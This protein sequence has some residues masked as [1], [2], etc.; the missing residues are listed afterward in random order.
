M[1]I[2]QAIAQRRSTYLSDPDWMEVPWSNVPKT[3]F[4]QL[5]DIMVALPSI[6]EQGHH[7]RGLTSTS[8]LLTALEIIDRCWKMDAKLSQFYKELEKKSLGP[9]YW[10]ELSNEEN[11]SDDIQ[12]GK[13]FPVAFHFL[14]P[15][16]AHICMLYWATLIILWS[17]LSY[18][19]KILAT[20]RVDEILKNIA[21]YCDEN[22]S[23]ASS[24][25]AICKRKDQARKLRLAFS[26]LEHLPPL[27]H[28]RDVVSIGRNICQS[29]E[30]CLLAEPRRLGPG[31]AYFPL[32]VAIEAFNDYPNCSR[33]LLWAKSAME[34]V[35]GRGIRLLKYLGVPVTY[36]TYLPVRMKRD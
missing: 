8:R 5:L 26:D 6:I 7:M 22:C 35:S 20:M 29:L 3:P 34:K 15:R 31:L 17:G 33:E 23:I 30:Y 14:N 24:K 21:H 13:V 18:M 2:A 12:L 27:E 11:P 1:Q 36:K 10:P 32:K 19:Y 9:L 28:R 16:T 25:D 4:H